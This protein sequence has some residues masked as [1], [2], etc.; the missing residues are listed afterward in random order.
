VRSDEY[1]KNSQVEITLTDGKK[2]TL[3]AMLPWDFVDLVGD[4]PDEFVSGE[5]SAKNIKT[6]NPK[7][8]NDMVKYMCVNCVLP[9]EGFK[10][11]D[12]PI[13]ETV[14]GE[15]SYRE[16]RAEDIA[17]VWI[18]VIK[19]SSFGKVDPAKAGRFPEGSETNTP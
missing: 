17:L 8:Y 11:V 5:E 16:M 13:N 18:Y 19:I 2:V 4:V 1:K 12:K 9:Q 10:I 15:I 7:L 14:P 6:T 3:R